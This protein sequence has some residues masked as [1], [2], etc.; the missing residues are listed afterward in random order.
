MSHNKK[1]QKG[2]GVVDKAEAL[3]FKLSGPTS[4]FKSGFSKAISP[5]TGIGELTRSAL[6][7]T[8]AA[9]TDTASA[10]G[11]DDQSTLGFVKDKEGNPS[12]A[13]KKLRTNLEEEEYWELLYDEPCWI[14]PNTKRFELKRLK[15]L[16]CNWVDEKAKKEIDNMTG[17]L[18]DFEINKEAMLQELTKEIT[19]GENNEKSGPGA[20]AE[21][22]VNA[23]M[24]KSD[25]GLYKNLQTV[26]DLNSLKT[27]LSPYL[28]DPVGFLDKHIKRGEKPGP[29]LIS[30]F[31]PDNLSETLNDPSG[32]SSGV[33]GSTC[34]WKKFQFC[35]WMKFLLGPGGFLLLKILPHVFR[36]FSKVLN[37]FIKVLYSTFNTAIAFPTL[38]MIQGPARLVYENEKGEDVIYAPNVIHSILSFLGT[39]IP[40]QYYSF[41]AGQMFGKG[42]FGK[43]IFMLMIVSIGI[44]FVGGLG[45]SMLL[46]GF[47]IYLFK[48]I[49]MFTNNIQKK[50]KK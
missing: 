15:Y 35:L 9:A 20:K 8:T 27:A 14:D 13:F 31:S 29:A 22:I 40:F 50:T 5:L 36:F 38:G 41:D 17:G 43:I 46:V 28:Q 42:E 47:V 11:F 24:G 37:V 39:V 10:I 33:L 49:G 21:D 26:A 12:F 44:I 25:D 4:V 2:G 48:I 3:G 19:N 45:T 7:V 18:G 23:F 34:D 30:F 16:W 6:D 32:V 1:I